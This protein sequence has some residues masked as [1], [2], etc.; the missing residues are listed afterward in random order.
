MIDEKLDN[1][2]PA[3]RDRQH[4]LV[5]LITLNPRI[6]CEYFTNPQERLRSCWPG[7]SDRAS[8][9]REELGRMLEEE[10]DGNKELQSDR[11]AQGIVNRLARLI[12]H[13]PEARSQYF[14]NPGRA[15]RRAV[16]RQGLERVWLTAPERVRLQREKLV[17][18]VERVIDL[19]PRLIS[20]REAYFEKKAFLNEALE[21]PQRTFN[22]IVGLSIVAFF[23]VIALVAGAFLAGFLGNGTTEKALLG[24]LSGGG[25]VLTSIGSVLAITSKRLRRAN[26]DSAQIRLILTSFA[27]QITHWRSLRIGRKAEQARE[28]NHEIREVTAEAVRMIEEYVEPREEKE[29]KPKE[30]RRQPDIGGAHSH[31]GQT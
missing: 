1:L 11:E 5:R 27:T 14:Q 23:A 19:D 10:I 22:T 30:T 8:A 18:E 13:N 6:R 20:T 7:K 4:N 26:G 12:T 9:L 3:D 28:I 17:D 25:G 16:P 15:L 31:P 24:G 29:K 21:N 2:A